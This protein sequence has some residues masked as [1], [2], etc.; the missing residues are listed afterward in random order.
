MVVG[1]GVDVVEISRFSRAVARHGDDFLDRLLTPTERTVCGQSGR[2]VFAES[3]ARFAAK[4]AVF[5]ALGTGW[6][7][8]ITWH[9]AELVDGAMRLT[10]EAGRV[11][12][13]AGV[14][15]VHVSTS[16]TR[17]HAMAMVVLEP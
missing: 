9:D 2:R 16:C 3:A 5:K 13:R 12:E 6:A 4:E 17:V 8:G 11:A 7:G 14:T 15:R 10:G 1:L